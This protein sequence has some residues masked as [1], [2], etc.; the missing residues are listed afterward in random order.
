MCHFNKY[1]VKNNVDTII[2]YTANCFRMKKLVFMASQKSIARI[3]DCFFATSD[4]K[5]LK[6]HYKKKGY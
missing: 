6:W 2:F 5:L 3:S 1:S 4:K